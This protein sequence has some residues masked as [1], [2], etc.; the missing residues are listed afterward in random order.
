MARESDPRNGDDGE[1]VWFED[2]DDFSGGEPG[3]GVVFECF[4]TY[5]VV[6]VAIRKGNAVSVGNT[7]NARSRNFVDSDV[8]R[9]SALR[10]SIDI[11]GTD[12]E[13]LIIR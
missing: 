12:F 10:R 4:R 9:R 7:V 1:A 13:K 6:K 3:C 2:S 8:M 11:S 5:N